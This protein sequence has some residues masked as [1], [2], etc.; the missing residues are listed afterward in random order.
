MI[1]LIRRVPVTAALLGGIAATALVKRSVDGAALEQA[2]STNLENL[3]RRP[4]RSLLASA[5]VAEGDHWIVPAVGT[6]VALGGLEY[7][8]GTRRAGVIAL[9]GHMLPTLLTQAAVWSG[10]RTGRLPASDSKRVDV[11]TS[12]VIMAALGGLATLLPARQRVAVSALAVAAAAGEIV[13][14]RHVLAAGHGLAFAVGYLSRPTRR[15]RGMPR[16]AA[17]IA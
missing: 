16:W 4:V 1:R 15:W 12:Y 13:A 7:L 2:A 14:T 8:A 17:C 10:V 6:A 9:A 11:G 3:A 5:V